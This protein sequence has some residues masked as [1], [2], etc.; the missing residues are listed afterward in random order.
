MQQTRLQHICLLLLVRAHVSHDSRRYNV[1]HHLDR[2]QCNH[3]HLALHAL[4]IVVPTRVTTM[5]KVFDQTRR[6]S[7]NVLLSR[8]GERCNSGVDNAG[9]APLELRGSLGSTSQNDALPLVMHGSVGRHIT[10][11]AEVGISAMSGRS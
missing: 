6:M 8:L 10:K 1:W 2:G 11:V 3:S 5:L 7:R 9:A 4:R